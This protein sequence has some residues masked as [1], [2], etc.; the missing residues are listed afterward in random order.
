M[1]YVPLDEAMAINDAGAI[2]GVVDGT[3]AVYAQGVVTLLPG[4]AGYTNLRALDISNT[5]Y[6]VGS[7]ESAGNL[8]P[9]FWQSASSPPLDMGGLGRYTYPQ[10]INDQGVVVGYYDATGQSAFIPFT[11][12]RATGYAQILPYGASS[13]QAFDISDTG[14]IAGVASYPTIGQQAVRWYPNGSAGRVADGAYA[15]RALDNGSVFGRGAGGSTL[16]NLSNAATLIGPEPVTHV[17]EQRNASL[18]WVG[19]TFPPNPRPWTS[20]DRGVAT[21][22]PMPSGAYGF[23][24]DVNGCGTVLGRVVGVDGISRPVFWSRIFCDSLPPI[25]AQ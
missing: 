14:Y 24:H 12:S 9:L 18:R 19:Y 11:W 13:A 10:A 20:V 1:S 17:V 3:A 25:V 5:G 22:L 23:A 4:K 6:I 7:G 15:K 8:R 16:W 2:V 21:Y